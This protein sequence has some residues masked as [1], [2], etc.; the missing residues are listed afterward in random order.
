MLDKKIDSR[1]SYFRGLAKQ[2]V[3]LEDAINKINN[4]WISIENSKN[5]TQKSEQPPD[6]TITRAMLAPI[7]KKCCLKLKVFEDFLQ[8]VNPELKAISRNLHNVELAKK[9]PVKVKRKGVR[10]TA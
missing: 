4:A 9:D 2:V 5:N 8:Q 10:W 6:S 7:F 1:E 3:A